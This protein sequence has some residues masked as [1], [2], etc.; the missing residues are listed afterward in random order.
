MKCPYTIYCDVCPDKLVC[1]GCIRENVEIDCVSNN[2][3]RM[4]SI[5]E[6]AECEFYNCGV[7]PTGA[8]RLKIKKRCSK[9]RCL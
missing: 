1:K 9:E 7:R 2:G 5:N 4:V 3:N 8:I 6:C